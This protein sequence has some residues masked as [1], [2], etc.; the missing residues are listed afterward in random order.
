MNMKLSE[1]LK[2]PVNSDAVFKLP[3]ALLKTAKVV[4][5][6]EQRDVFSVSFNAEGKLL[7]VFF[8]KSG[9]E[10]SAYV[11][12]EE[13][14]L[15]SRDIAVIKRMWTLPALQK[16]GYISG[17]LKFIRDFIKMSIM[18][19]SEQ[20]PSART[21]WNS[22]G[23]KFDVKVFDLK[24]GEIKQKSEFADTDIYSNSAATKYRLFLDSNSVKKEIKEWVD[25]VLTPY[26]YFEKGD[27]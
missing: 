16:Q 24:S 15:F 1:I 5:K 25:P 12:V 10:L 14:E 20:T 23:N 13:V 8:N 2:I 7:Y 11:I 6:S 17:L 9:D 27:E 18:S 22:I 3:D 19:D 21:F 4:G 26:C